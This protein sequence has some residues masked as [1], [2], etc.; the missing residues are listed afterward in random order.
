MTFIQHTYTYTKVAPETWAA[1]PGYDGLYTVSDAG[2]VHNVKARADV[3]AHTLRGQLVV[4]LYRVSGVK[5][6]ALLGGLVLEAFECPP[7]YRGAIVIHKNGRMTDC[8]LINLEWAKP[9]RTFSPSFMASGQVG[10]RARWMA[11]SQSSQWRIFV[12]AKFSRV[13]SARAGAGR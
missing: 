13:S 4:T 3:P 2:R 5:D 7:P 8:R 6:D 11:G 9:Q 1:A 10:G 12:P